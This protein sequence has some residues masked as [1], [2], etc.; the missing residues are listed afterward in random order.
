MRDCREIGISES[1]LPELESIRQLLL[2][3][4]DATEVL[5]YKIYKQY[6]NL[7]NRA[8]YLIE[9]KEYNKAKKGYEVT[10][11]ELEALNKIIKLFGEVTDSGTL[12]TLGSILYTDAPIKITPNVNTITLITSGYLKPKGSTFLKR[13]IRR[14]KLSAIAKLKPQHNYI[15]EY[16]DGSTDKFTFN[17]P[18]SYRELKNVVC[19]GKDNP[20]TP[21]T[22]KQVAR[23]YE[24][25]E[26]GRALGAYNARFQDEYGNHF[27]MFDLDSMVLLFDLNGLWTDK[28]RPIKGYKL[29]Q[30]LTLEEQQEV[31]N[32]IFASIAFDKNG[33]YKY[34]KQKYAIIPKFDKDFMSKLIGLCVN[35]DGSINNDKIIN[36]ITDL[37]KVAKVSAHKMLQNDLFKL[38]DNYKG[39][40]RRIYANRTLINPT[41][42]E[43]DAYE[44]IL[45]Q[46]YQTVFGLQEGDI[47]EDILKDKDFFIKRGLDR[48][49]CKLDHSDYDYELKNFNGE[50]IYLVDRSHGIPSH[51]QGLPIFTETRN[52]KHYRLDSNGN[53]LY[54]MASEHD[55]VCKVGDVQVIV[56]DNPMF[57][58]NSMN[59]NTLKVSPKRV[60]QESYDSLVENLKESKRTNS[61]NFMKAITIGEGSVMDLKTFKEFNTAIDNITYESVKQTEGDKDFKSVAQICNILLKNGRELHVSFEQSLEMVAGRIPAQS[62]QSF[63]IQRVVGFDSSGLNTAMVSTF[64]LFLQGS[65]LDIDAVTMLGYE[66]DH[67]G[68][69]VG[70]SPYFKIDTKDKLKASKKIPLL[71]GQ[72][73]TVNVSPKAPNNFFE[74]YDKYFGTLFQT[75]KLPT[76]ED[77]FKTKDGVLELQMV[78]DTPEGVE[79]L[80]QF[81]RDFNEYG[82]NIQ[83]EMVESESGILIKTDSENFFKRTDAAGNVVG[84][85]NLFMHRTAGGAIGARPDQVY[86]MAEQIL[87]F[88]NDHNDYLNTAKEHLKDKMAKNYVVHYIYKVAEALCNQT[89]AQVGLDISTRDVKGA[90]GRSAMANASN[91][92]APGGAEVKHKSVGEGQVGKSCVGI[93][94][95]GIKANSTT[96][97]YI[98]EILNYGSDWDREKIMFKRPITIGGVTY[99]GFANMHTSKQF[100][101]R[102]MANVQAALEYINALEHPDQLTPDVAVN[103]A[104][105]LSIA[106]DN[107]KDLALAKINSGPKMMGLY[108]YGLTLGIPINDLVAIINSDEGRILTELTE[109]SYFNNDT[110]A[111][112]VLDAIKKLDGNVIGDLDKYSYV[113][114]NAQGKAVKVTT[115]ISID[116][117]VRDIASTHEA[118]FTLMYE[119]YTRWF[120]SVKEQPWFKK[121]VSKNPILATSFS[122]ML[123]HL[124]LGNAFKDVFDSSKYLIEGF[125]NKHIIPSAKAS[126]ATNWI[127]SLYQMVSYLE[128]MQTKINKFKSSKGRDL[129]KLAQGAEEMR[130]LGSILSINKGLKA[131]ASEAEAFID[132]I[133]NL[134]YDRKKVL[135]MKVNEDDRLDF[136]R[137]MTDEE[138]QRQ[139]IDEYEKV[140]HS[141]NI[142]HLIS[143]VPHFNGYLKT[144]MIPSA[145]FMTSSIKYRTIHKF[146][147]NIYADKSG[148]KVVPLFDL[149]E[150][151]GNK[152]KEA[153]L[154]GLENLVHYKMFT[155]WAY[156]QKLQFKVPAGF[157][158]FTK[159]NE[160]VSNPNG[161]TVIDLWT[162]HGMATF[163]KYMEEV[164]IPMLK[165]S[166]IADNPFI[167]G[168]RKISYDKTPVHTSV[169]AYSLPGDLMSKKGSQGE[170]NA[171]T[172][173]SF[174]NLDSIVFQEDSKIYSLHDAFYIYAQYCYMGRKGQKSLMALF[175]NETSRKGLA[176]SFTEHIAKMDVDGNITCSKS[177][178]IAWCAPYGGQYLNSKY[179][180]VTSKDE[181][182]VSL[183]QKREVA[184]RIKEDPDNPSDVDPS[185]VEF[186]S[187]EDIGG[188]VSVKKPEN[189]RQ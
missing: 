79:L 26:E 165:D 74:I 105:L 54:E 82:I 68:K 166:S 117:K 43:V 149:F 14:K 1:L 5:P 98:S 142:L 132:T 7:I 187:A 96:Q 2:K 140:K 168:L 181:F 167:L 139:K 178:L 84:E 136:I 9:G 63:M 114:R 3:E 101:E 128:D 125:I 154:R 29:F 100:S 88:A 179:G 89:E 6:E 161:E 99:S 17:T 159:R 80:A 97:F 146:R 164:Y 176:K 112:K 121:S 150:V 19:F 10:P 94:A 92:Y 39:T 73:T 60:T 69:F 40:D 126:E 50:H 45:P 25:V 111:F 31:L 85:W 130:I 67:N 163:K 42:I 37:H 104:S 147:R 103:I 118:L 189:F 135:G 110:T 122:G 109:G 183:K 53:V 120:N 52:G 106:V 44:T 13:T 66:F 173:A 64:Q 115:T 156:D 145:F 11:S 78:Y 86:A 113:S 141:V 49:A 182:G 16:T 107:A 55:D 21:G 102:D 143:K 137:F 28:D 119:A 162:Q 158:Y 151:S 134:I 23:I 70:W 20:D 133:E 18:V 75:I 58:I 180:Y 71:T 152:E 33:V 129:R 46:I 72:K 153:I 65:D 38:S 144:Q 127:A 131:T 95:V 138:Y 172:F 123:K 186:V 27:N 12:N 22:K 148:E 47:V 188:Y 171:H 59:Y 32:K 116:G 170:I 108:A 30:N 160:L 36:I 83:G 93:G 76:G 169:T 24:N 77:K 41:N 87:K 157:K 175:D 61:Q 56:T 57:Y 177:E 91:S 15:I 81:L 34:L 35:E 124:L 184:S 185:D 62:Q 8:T 155:R 174:Q 4:E 51:L 48:F 90:A